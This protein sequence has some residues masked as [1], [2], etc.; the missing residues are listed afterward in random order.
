MIPEVPVSIR[1]LTAEEE[2]M[3]T[4]ESRKRP[5]KDDNVGSKRKKYNIC[6]TN[7]F[8]KIKE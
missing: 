7:K 3:Y 8:K 2:K 5:R 6:L 1:K 4:V